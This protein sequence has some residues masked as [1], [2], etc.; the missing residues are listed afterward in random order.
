MIK[1]KITLIL[2]KPI[3]ETSEPEEKGQHKG[4]PPSISQSVNF[5]NFVIFF[6]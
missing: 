6:I 5:A 1:Q 4:E 2:L 3:L